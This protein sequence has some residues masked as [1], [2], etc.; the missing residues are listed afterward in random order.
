[1]SAF[2]LR[3]VN[4]FLLCVLICLL[5]EGLSVLISCCRLLL[6]FWTNF[7][8]HVISLYVVLILLKRFLDHMIF[9][10][11]HP[12]NLIDDRLP[13]TFLH[14]KARCVCLVSAGS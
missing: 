5:I 1:M 13:F 11:F 14:L 2:L 9:L 8:V 7:L 12:R 4:R 6:I 3:H 10:Y